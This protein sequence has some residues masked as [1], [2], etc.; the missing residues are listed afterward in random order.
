[1]A[2]TTQRQINLGEV[3]C[4]NFA[5]RKSNVLLKTVFLAVYFVCM[6]F[7]FVK[8]A[9]VVLAQNRALYRK[10]NAKKIVCR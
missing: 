10:F 8:H 4:Y 2:K 1:M 3:L 7:S 9:S 6:A 5:K